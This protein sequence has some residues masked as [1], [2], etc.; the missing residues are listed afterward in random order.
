MGFNKNYKNFYLKDG[1][2]VNS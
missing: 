2:T 1:V